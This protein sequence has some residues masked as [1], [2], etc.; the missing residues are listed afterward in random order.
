MGSSVA[1]GRLC[2]DI[3]V[4][5]LEL[6]VRP[7]TLSLLPTAPLKLLKTKIARQLGVP[8][9]SRFGLSVREAGMNEAREVADDDRTNVSSLDLAEGD[10]VLVKVL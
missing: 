4:E 3:A 10:A 2:P 1:D 9:N 5:C 6:G 8:V 7:F